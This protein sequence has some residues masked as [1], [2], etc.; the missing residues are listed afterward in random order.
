M[1]L[2]DFILKKGSGKSTL[3]DKEY[4]K[5][6]K[7]V[8]TLSDEEDSTR[9][10]VYNLIIRELFNVDDGKY[11]QEIKYR[12]TDGENPNLVMLDIISRYKND[13]LSGLVWVLKR[14]VEEYA[15]EDFFKRF[16]K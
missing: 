8:V 12:F 2:F 1:E 3:L 9:W 5:L 10:E 14:R 13:E 16:Y 6:I 4:R 7:D 15:D 11:F